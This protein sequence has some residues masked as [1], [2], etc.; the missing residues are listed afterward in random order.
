MTFLKGE[1][2][3]HPKPGSTIKVDPIRD[4]LAIQKI[5]QT[6]VKN[7]RNLCFFT[8]G[9]NTGYR[10][11]ELLSIRVEQVRYLKSGDL[12]DVKQPKT[13]RYRQVKINRVTYEGTS[14]N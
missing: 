7:P 9:L 13:K 6:L 4:K 3:H 8:F 1:N 10:A 14:I 11:S 2:P 5:K 12:L